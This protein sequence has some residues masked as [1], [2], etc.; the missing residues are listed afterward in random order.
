M[1]V[2]ELELEYG[3][4]RGANAEE[5]SE[6]SRPVNVKQEVLVK[7]EAQIK[8]EQLIEDDSREFKR[9]PGLCTPTSSG[10]WSDDS[11]SSGQGCRICGSVAALLPGT[12]YFARHFF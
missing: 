2:L 5:Y 12:F 8:Q 7:Q 3:E 11:G 4:A 9:E 10:Y 6:K 1:F